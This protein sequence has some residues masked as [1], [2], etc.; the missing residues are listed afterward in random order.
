MI[1]PL[2]D[3]L[4]PVPDADAQGHS[5]K[6]VTRVHEAIA[7]NGG[8]LP[9]ASYMQIVLYEPAL[10]YYASGTRKFGEGGDFVTAP[11]LTALFG[12][13]LAVQSNAIRASTSN[14][15]L[16]LG[17]GTGKLAADLLMHLEGRDARAWRYRILEPSPE[18]RERQRA[19]IRERAPA[20]ASRVDWI[21]T[22]PSRIDGVVVMNEVLDALPVHIVVRRAGRWYERGVVG[23]G[24]LALEER[25]LGD[26]ALR[27]LAQLRF[28]AA[29]DYAS[30][31]NPAA[32]ALVASLAQRLAQ[33]ALLIVDYGF[34]RHEYYHP[35]RTSGT[36][37]AHYRHRVHS[38]PLLWPGLCDLTAHVDFTAIADAGARAG[39]DIA[40]FATQTAFLLGC[41]IVD[42]LRET[43][44]PESIAYVKQASAVQTLL[45]PAEM[46]ELFKVL[47][48]S[49]GEG[50]AWPGFAVRDMR[51]RLGVADS[52]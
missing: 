3:A 2:P 9:F 13:S 49:R 25:P 22:L 26:G 23:A 42:A 43:G 12:R 19:T 30:E 10:G 41:G 32:E 50:I 35:Q 29:I 47:A 17:A 11:E 4:L 52:V 6:V 33:G 7:R 51:H 14:D 46:G 1:R 39:L 16:E 37:V 21:D 24:E 31:I 34:P 45:S 44:A 27:R 36:L 40:G 48:L 15:V 5:A 20:H 38:D 28:P 18:L 8:W